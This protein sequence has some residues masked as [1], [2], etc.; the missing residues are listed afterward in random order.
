MP[1]NRYHVPLFP[2]YSP[3]IAFRPVYGPF[4][5]RSFFHPG[6]VFHPCDRKKSQGWGT[7]AFEV[8]QWAGRPPARTTKVCP[9]L[10]EGFLS[11]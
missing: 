2:P 3:Q 4:R 1:G 7:R 6:A 8:I 5:L 11:Q 10:S 9:S